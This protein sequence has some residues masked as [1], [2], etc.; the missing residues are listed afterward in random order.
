MLELAK[1]LN[2]DIVLE[3]IKLS[4]Q[5]RNTERLMFKQLVTNQIQQ[6]AEA[7]K[8]TLLDVLNSLSDEQVIELMA[9]MWLGRGDYDSGTVKDAFAD[10]MDVAR[11]SFKREEVG[12]LIDK[13]LKAY[14]LK[15]LEF[16]ADGTL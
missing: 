6:D 9:L 11:K 8:R 13:P 2:S 15:A 3:I 5:S 10:A 7:P 12:Y 1:S 14:L 16:D 4:D